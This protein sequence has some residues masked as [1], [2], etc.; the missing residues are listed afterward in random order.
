M[1]PPKAEYPW[2]AKLLVESIK[3]FGITTV[4]VCV[5]LYMMVEVIIPEMVRVAN[6]YC[7]SAEQT[8]KQM[9]G[10]Q[11]R[12]VDNQEAQINNQDQIVETQKQ[13]VEV[14]QDVSLAAK[15]IIACEQQ[16]QA[17]LNNVESFMS[18]VKEDHSKQSES[19]EQI[20]TA[21]VKPPE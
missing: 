15:E 19:L 13:L 2:Y 20:K 6:R 5:L 4:I 14:V 8:Q 17:V 12:L 16:S 11:E 7:D 3:S 9:I 21:V 10:M 18:S 1:T